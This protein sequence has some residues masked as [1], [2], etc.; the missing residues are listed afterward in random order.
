LFAELRLKAELFACVPLPG[1]FGVPL[2]ARASEG[3]AVIQAK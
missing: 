1:K 3:P 2:V